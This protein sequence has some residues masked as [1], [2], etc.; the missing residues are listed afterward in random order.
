MGDNSSAEVV[1]VG[2]GFM[3]RALLGGWLRSGIDPRKITVCD[4]T[5]NEWLLSQSHVRINLPI[6][7]NPAI[8]VFA[9]KPQLLRDVLTKFENFNGGS[10]V[11]VSVAAGFTLCDFEQQL[12][13]NT[14]VVR[15]MPN[16]PAS[17]GAG[18]TAIVAN[19]AT[20][21]DQVLAVQQLF[22]AVGTVVRLSEESDMHI[23]TALSGSGPAY[24]FAMV[25]ALSQTGAANGLPLE[26]ATQLAT[27]TV[28]GAGKMLMQPGSSA[29]SL[30]KSVTSPAGTTA[31]GLCELTEEA[32]GISPLIARTIEAAKRR[33]EELAGL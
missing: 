2:C 11:F 15:T 21:A 28:V 33:S 14:P 29:A 5:P 26:V 8:I 25:E 18:V 20:T 17:V 9:V 24:I 23:V 27:Q 30:R 13:S 10:T 12:G 31:A 16:L 22:E 7:E 4:P 6:P 3:G 32:N 1:L 19:N